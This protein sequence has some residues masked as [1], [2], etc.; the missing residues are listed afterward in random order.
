MK[1]LKRDKKSGSGL[2]T[3]RGSA[4]S[5]YIAGGD[6]GLLP[7]WNHRVWWIQDVIAKA[8]YEKYGKLKTKKAKEPFMMGIEEIRD[9]E[10]I[11]Q[12][13]KLKD[14]KEYY[15]TTCKVE[16]SCSDIRNWTNQKRLSN[17][18]IFNLVEEFSK[19]TL[20]R[21][22]KRKIMKDG[23]LTTFSFRF[24]HPW[25]IEFHFTGQ[26]SNRHKVKEFYFEVFFDTAPSIDF[27]N[28]VRLGLFDHRP[29]SY[30]HLRGATQRIIRAIGWT[31]RI[32]RPSLKRLVEIAGIKNK[33]RSEQQKQIESYLE[34][35]EQAGYIS[36][37]E[38]IGN[39]KGKGLGG[40]KDITYFIDKVDR[41]PKR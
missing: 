6:V 12:I 28:C 37:Y 36:A 21:Q 35:A 4:F 23:E 25:N 1:E 29:I 17:G 27:A 18:D 22:T 20:W 15:N 9:E 33:N 34:E 24:I 19:F 3:E 38:D 39:K 7:K 31:G 40:R 2:I 16:F 26:T 8:I 10:R 30:Y 11:L 13:L 14:E 32:S 41:W 5:M